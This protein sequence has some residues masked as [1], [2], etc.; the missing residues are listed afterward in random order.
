MCTFPLSLRPAHKNHVLLA[1]GTHRVT[2]P[3]VL[4]SGQRLIGA[5]SGKTIISGAK[6]VS[7]TKQGS[8]SVIQG[9]TNLGQPRYRQ[10]E[11]AV[12]SASRGDGI[13]R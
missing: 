13:R 11:M 8:Y 6:V 2:A 3:L 12:R 1:A 10:G 5:G 7:A 4:K 9:Q